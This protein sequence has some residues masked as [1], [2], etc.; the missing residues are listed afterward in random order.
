MMQNLGNRR[1]VQKCAQNA[2]SNVLKNLCNKRERKSF[3]E[4]NI[5][6]IHR[7]AQ[8]NPCFFRIACSD[9]AL[10]HFEISFSSLKKEP[11]ITLPV[12]VVS[13]VSTV[14]FTPV[15]VPAAHCPSTNVRVKAC[16]QAFYFNFILF[17]L[18]DQ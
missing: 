11:R 9:I 14:G 15:V 1:S 2:G 8:K 16:H 5:H 17:I 18:S 10:L 4:Q 6:G 7:S 3:C 13:E 12:T